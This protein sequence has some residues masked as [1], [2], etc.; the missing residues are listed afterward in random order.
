MLV[1]HAFA[2]A[3]SSRRASSCEAPL[4]SFQRRSPWLSDHYNRENVSFGLP[5]LE[6]ES[7]FHDEVSEMSAAEVQ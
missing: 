7:N 3:P 1:P 4:V 6:F 2:A 5:E